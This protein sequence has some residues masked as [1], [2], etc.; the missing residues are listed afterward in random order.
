MS[1]LP[2][3]NITFD[4]GT[5]YAWAIDVPLTP[6]GKN[7]KSA[8]QEARF[9]A[10]KTGRAF[11]GKRLTQKQIL[12]QEQAKQQQIDK[13]RQAHLARR[14]LLPRQQLLDEAKARGIKNR[15][16]MNRLQ[17]VEAIEDAIKNRKGYKQRV[18]SL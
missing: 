15:H 7:R 1:A 3:I 14:A 4:N 9:I 11:F 2:P 12:R 16:R 8:A 17:L 10:Q 18:L 5:W 6:V 13:G